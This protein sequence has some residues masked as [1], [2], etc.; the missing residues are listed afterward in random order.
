MLCCSALSTGAQATSRQSQA[1]VRSRFGV[2]LHGSARVHPRVPKGN[3]DPD[4]PIRY[5]T[6]PRASNPGGSPAGMQ[7]RGTL[8]DGCGSITNQRNNVQNVTRALFCA[9]YITTLARTKYGPGVSGFGATWHSC[10]RCQIIG[11]MSAE[12]RITF[13]EYSRVNPRGSAYWGRVENLNPDMDPA[14]PR[15]Q[16]REWTRYP[17]RTLKTRQHGRQGV[18][19]ENILGLHD[20]RGIRQEGGD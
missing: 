9:G 20:L 5:P 8:R 19:T 7:T 13:A 18:G 3:P 16:T 4:L 1:R 14:D 2:D 10:C 17:C 6:D 15:V 11:K 12:P